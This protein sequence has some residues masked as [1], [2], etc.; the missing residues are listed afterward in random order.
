MKGP[1]VRVG[2]FSI[3]NGIDNRP[4]MKPFL[5]SQFLLTNATAVHLFAE[6]AEKMPIIDYHSHLNPRMIA[7]DHQFENITQAWLYGDHYKWRAMRA[8]G[9][10]EKYIT[11]DASDYEKF[12]KW[13]ETV[14]YTLGNPL[15][16]WTHL[17]L[18][19][20]FGITE[21]LSPATC[22]SIYEKAS[23]M[24][25]QPDFSV[26]SLLERMN[27]KVVC[28]TDDPLDSLDYHSQIAES[29]W[30]VKVLPTWRPDKLLAFDQPETWNKY[31]DSL[32]EITGITITRYN[33]LL[34][35]V[36]LRHDFFHDGGCRLSD[37]GLETFPE[38]DFNQPDA[39]GYFEALRRHSPP[40]TGSIQ[41]HRLINA[42]LLD[43]A[44]LDHEKGWV[45]QFHMGALRS[46][47]TRALREL[48]PDTGFD[49]ISD[50]LLARPLAGFLNHLESESRL[51]KTILYNLNPA[52]NEVMAAMTGNFQDGSVPGKI[53]WGS[54]WWFLDQK[55]G[56]EAQL[57]TLANFGL[58]SRF[59][60]M[61]TDSRSFLS[62][63]RH[64]YFR[65]ILCNFIGEA[66]ER[67]EWP[68]DEVWTGSVV[69][70]ICYRN[71]KEYFPF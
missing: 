13:A 37:H 45:Q 54:A 29:G 51:T 16:H 66:V 69:E 61:L 65:R 5:D 21:R 56:M 23:S 55:D 60:G 39:A 71:A 49:S 63:P 15:Y 52:Y 70:G 42:L 59:V 3:P 9:I 50:Q 8:N 67:G 33:D 11:G 58:L 43:L 19:R 7:G 27:V 24:L 44:R 4:A 1:T 36:R 10:H 6:H 25:R 48:G 38:A 53:Q 35:A 46:T 62:Y 28:T 32:S 20:Y 57:K 22:R 64:E 68:D 12:E 47:N 26:R 30:K 31:I 17:E 14:P 40:V 18:Q 2:N 41:H 34:D